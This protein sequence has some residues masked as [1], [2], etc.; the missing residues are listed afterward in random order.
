MKISTLDKKR[1][2]VVFILL[3]YCYKCM[4]FVSINMLLYHKILVLATNESTAETSFSIE[5]EHR[6]DSQQFFNL[7]EIEEETNQDKQ[8]QETSDLLTNKSTVETLPGNKKKDGVDN[9]RLLESKK[10][11]KKLNRDEKIEKNCKFLMKMLKVSIIIIIICFSVVG[12][13]WFLA[14]ISNH[15]GNINKQSVYSSHSMLYMNTHHDQNKNINEISQIQNINGCNRRFLNENPPVNIYKNYHTEERCACSMILDSVYRLQNKNVRSLSS[16]EGA[17]FLKA[18]Y[19]KGPFFAET[20]NINYFLCE[21]ENHNS[22]KN[23]TSVWIKGWE[24]GKQKLDYFM[25]EELY[26]FYPQNLE[27]SNDTIKSDI[28]EVDKS[29]SKD[30]CHSN[31]NFDI[32]FFYELFVKNFA[33]SNTNLVIKTG[34]NFDEKNSFFAILKMWNAHLVNLFQQDQENKSYVP[35]FVQWMLGLEKIHSLLL[36]KSEELDSQQKIAIKNLNFVI[37]QAD[38]YKN[39]LEE[40][41]KQR[42]GIQDSQLESFKRSDYR[43]ERLLDIFFYGASHDLI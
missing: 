12:V 30:Y 9:Q 17:K 28:I 22:I 32:S 21:H 6:R 20:L 8:T 41:I 15:F 5:N 36:N 38:K 37:N 7:E 2:I 31:N 40:Y 18:M 11:K 4:V 23:F 16:E 13:F 39:L 25:S 24:F 26:L 29:V 10:N 27:F 35:S 1:N 42:F 3:C 43:F 19:K 34:S 33:L 14:F